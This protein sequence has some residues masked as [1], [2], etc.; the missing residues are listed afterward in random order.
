MTGLS[1][2]TISLTVFKNVKQLNEFGNLFIRMLSA[3]KSKRKIIC[4][5]NVIGDGSMDGFFF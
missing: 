2:L 1:V 3:T 4:F 5:E